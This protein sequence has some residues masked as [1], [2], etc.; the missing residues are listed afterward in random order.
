MHKKILLLFVHLEGNSNLFENIFV[1]DSF[2]KVRMIMKIFKRRKLRFRFYLL[3][4]LVFVFAVWLNIELFK[5]ENITCLTAGG[6]ICNQIFLYTI[7]EFTAYGSIMLFALML[8]YIYIFNCNEVIKVVTKNEEVIEIVETPLITQ[9]VVVKTKKV[10]VIVRYKKDIINYV[11]SNTEL[12]NYKSSQVINVIFDE[13]KN[14]LVQGNQV[15]I[16]GFGTFKKYKVQEHAGVNPGT[17]ESIVI[18]AHNRIKFTASRELKSLFINQI[19]DFSNKEYV[20]AVPI[21]QIEESTSTQSKVEI[22]KQGNLTKKN[23][24]DVV[25]KYKQDIIKAIMVSTELSKSKSSLFLNTFVKEICHSLIEGKTVN[26]EELGT[27]KK[28]RVESHKGVNPAT[29]K[30]IVIEA[31]NRIKYIPSKLLKIKL[32]K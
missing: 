29:Q 9:L 11:T 15:N 22:K 27:F 13:I 23:K 16:Q 6:G 12:S 24:S 10:K 7:F 20:T 18:E 26:I 28:Y 17:G 19:P 14:Q 3:V 8:I 21:P 2:R 31:H 30:E 1:K 5:M 25:V 4:L 32:N